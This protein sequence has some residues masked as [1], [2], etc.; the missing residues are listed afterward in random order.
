MSELKRTPLFDEHVRLKGKLVDFAGWEMPLQFDSIIN[1]HN[2]VRKVAGLFDVSHM[3]EIE[4]EG[5]DAIHFSDYLVTNSVSSLK[6]G[7]IVYSPMCNE[8]GGIVD[9]VLVYRL[10]NAKTMFVV[11]ASNKDKDFKWI[12]S[13]KGSFDVRIKDASADFAQIAFQGPRAEEILSEVSQVRLEKIPFYHFEYGRVNGIKAL[14]SRTGYT[15]EDGFEL[16]VDP[17][18]VVALWRKILELGSSIGV[19]PIGLGARDTLRFE[20]AYMLYGNEL[21]DYNSPLEAGLKWTVKMEKDF[22][23]KEVLQEQLAN[24]TKYKLKGLELSGKSIARHGFEVFDGEKKIGWITS[25]IFSPTLQKSLALA[26]LEKEY[27]KIGSEVQVEIRGKRSPATV[28]KTPFYRGS[29][30]SKG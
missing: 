10:S 27:W 16:Y 23:G 17:E 13:N 15:G 6:N 21:N 14:V 12:T 7:A 29:V 18:A 25:G 2:L 24:G 11:N 19:K 1:E 20:A 4:I 8:K 28:V 26:Y 3:G 30:K 9:D 5:P 22:I